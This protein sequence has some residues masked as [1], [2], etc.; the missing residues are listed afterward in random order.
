MNY[1]INRN[2]KQVIEMIIND[3]QFEEYIEDK[4]KGLEVDDRKESLDN[5]LKFVK[6]HTIE[7]F[8]EYAYMSMDKPQEVKDK[9][10]IQLMTIHKSKGLE[11]DT[12]FVIGVKDGKFPSERG[13]IVEEARLFYVAVTR[14]KNNLFIN[15]IGSY[16]KF[17]VE[18]VG[19]DN[20]LYKIP[21]LR[22]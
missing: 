8:L 13:E 15:Q 3:F 11:F 20:G 1:T 4:Y 2:L 7:S 14:A 17:I 9:N 19:E 10:T 22:V 6:G 18:Y 12:V 5:L 21:Q 16:N